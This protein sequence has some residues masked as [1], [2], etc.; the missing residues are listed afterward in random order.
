MRCGDLFRIIPNAAAAP[1]TVGG[2]PTH[3]ATGPE[4]GPGR[5]SRITTASQETGR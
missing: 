2:H 4:A 1:A 3:D 5:R